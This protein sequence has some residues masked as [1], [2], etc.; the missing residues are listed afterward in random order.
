MSNS[1]VG[2]LTPDKM[3][4]LIENR[5]G[6]SGDSLILGPGAGLDF[7]VLDC[8]NG[9][10][11]AI[12]EDP[13][14]PAAGLPLEMM[15][16]FTVHIGASDVAVSGIKPS[17]MT[18]SLLLPP[19]TPVE[20]TEKIIQKISDTA[21]ALDIAIAGGHTGW[22]SA[23]SLPIVGGITVWG[24]AP[25]D[26]WVSPGGAQPGD[27][28]LMTKGPAI[29]A[30][31]L[32]GVLYSQKE[33]PLPRETLESLAGRV[34]QITVVEDALTAWEAGGVHAMHDATEGGVYCGMWEM[35][36]A[37]GAGLEARLSRDMVP[38]DIQALADYLRF[39]PWAAISEGT[40]LAAV[41]PESAGAV[42]EAWSRKGI[43]SYVL[44]TF[45]EGKTSLV[46][47]GRETAFREPEA[48]PFWNLFDNALK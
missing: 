25:K 14:F 21:K 46:T 39:D 47:D 16:E 36:N 42:R 10:V 13:I 24:F 23:V 32:L 38:A 44:G 41:S 30:A 27:L 48:D 43:D 3:N 4:A 18:Y 19:G 6:A 40:L 45:T 2:K 9:M 11:M 8:G 20:E 37:S 35:K 17:F 22:Y 15:G 28:L 33:T 31:A 7:G 26:K 1:H 12:A 34:S 5:L 29:E